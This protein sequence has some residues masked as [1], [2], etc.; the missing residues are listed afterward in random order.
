MNLFKKQNIELDFKNSSY[1]KIG[2]F[3]QQMTK[4]GVI[5]YKEAKKGGQPQIVSIDRSNE[6]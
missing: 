3:L 2:K 6:Q 4:E 1:Q 5:E